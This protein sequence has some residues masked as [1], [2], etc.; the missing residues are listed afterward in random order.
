MPRLLS[1]LTGITGR[2]T[3]RLVFIVSISILITATLGYIK[4]Y[5]VTATNSAIRIDRAARA[6]TA[7][8]TEQLASEFVAI[9]DQDGRPQAIRLK[10]ATTEESLSFR[11]AHDALLKEIG[12]INQGAAN[13]FRL[14]PETNAFDRFATTFRKPDGSM[15]PPM[16][17][18]I[19]HPAYD[20]LINNRPHLGEVPV[21]GRLRLAYLTPIQAASGTIEGA[22]AV[23]V[24][25]VDDL[26][27]AKNELRTQIIIAAVLILVLVAAFGAINMSGELRPLRELAGYA[28][29]LAAE[30]PA[31][32]VPYKNRHDEIGA[33]AQGLERVVALQGKLAHLAYTDDLTGLSN[34]S[35]Y[36]SDLDTALSESLSGKRKWTLLHLDMDNFK[37]INDV[38]GQTTGDSLLKMVASKIEQ[39]AGKGS[40]I[41]RLAADHFTILIGDGSSIEQ[42]S[43][44][45]E[46]LLNAIHQ[47]FQLSVGEIRVSASVGIVLLQHDARDAD[48][49]HRNA[50][51]ALRKAK[52]KG[53]R[54]VF[55]SSEL[56]DEFQNHIRM[57]RMLRLA[58]ADREIEVHFQPQFNPANNQLAGVEALARWT[59]P[60]EGPI[61]PGKFIPIA[62]AG[63]QIVDLGTLVLDLACEQAAKWRAAKF[64]FKHISVNVS[65]IQ[66]WQTNFVAVVKDA[67]KR[68]DLSGNEICI[69][70]TEGV[71]VDQSEKRIEKVLAAVRELGVLLSLDDFGS[72][73]S[74]LGYL[75]RL[76]FDQLKIDRSFVSD[77][78]TDL[79]KQKV[80][81]GILELGRGL[82]FNIVVEGAETSEEVAVI[83]NMGCDAIQGFYFSRPAPALL[84]PEVVKKISRSQPE[85]EVR[86]A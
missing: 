78:D 81:G 34:R 85:S 56:H 51:L 1:L 33:L 46:R 82:G 27:I 3:T 55:F 37:Q 44:V 70:I 38:Y 8:F 48:E 66:L 21:M 61:S 26:V 80:L 67:L 10:G 72:G 39:V 24:G 9:R 47:P 64:D 29:D 28:E 15:P 52:L 31:G 2:I 18:G 11:D 22:L 69:E 73:Y 59:H 32:T 14:N 75:N 36:L 58:I 30:A 20:N 62:E 40:R 42:V 6:A 83:R 86:S 13:L 57:E 76:P 49:A 53:D 71:F 74:S 23:D 50:G 54:T 5:E 63:G 7:L 12:S 68:H 35:R 79:R 16:S 25:W 4:L 17:I 77:I 43:T 19:M 65:P 41:A 45:A 60:A 84:V